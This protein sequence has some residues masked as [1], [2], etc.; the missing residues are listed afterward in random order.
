MP[1]VSVISNSFNS[2]IFGKRMYGR[3]DF[4]RYKNAAE[5]IENFLLAPQGGLRR[6]PGTA[7]VGEVRD[8]SKYVR[9]VDFEFSSVDSYVL[10]LNDGRIEFLRNNGFV[11][12]ATKNI[13]SATNDSPGVIEV[14]SHGFSNGDRVYFDGLGGMTEL[15]DNIY[16]IAGVTTHTFTLL[17]RAGSAVNTTGYG[18]YTTGGT[19]ARIYSIAHPYSDAELAQIKWAQDNDTIYV[20]CPTKMVR[21]IIRAG[22]TSWTLTEVEFTF[23]PF[24]KDNSVV[25]HTMSS[26]GTTG[27]VT[28]T[29]STAYFN[30]NHV[31][32]LLKMAG[33]T[34]TPARQGY[35]LITAYTSSTV[36]TGTVKHTLSSGSATDAWAI[37]S[38]SVDAGFPRAI[39]FHESRLYLGGTTK[40]PRN[41]WGSVVEDFENMEIDAEDDSALDLPILVVKGTPILWLASE[42]V[43]VA[44]SSDG[45]VKI[46]AGG[47]ST[48]TP[49]N[50]SAK[51]QTSVGVADVS[52]ANIGSFVYYIQRDK[53]TLREF[54]FVFESDRY[55]AHNM[56]VFADSIMS[57]GVV[58]MAFQQAP[59]GILYASLVD[60]KIITFTREREQEVMGYAEQTTDGLFKDVLVIS[61]ETFDEVWVIVSRTVDGTNRQY[62]EYFMPDEFSDQEDA[63]FVDSGLEYDASPADVFS[64]LEHLEGEIVSVLADGAVHPNCTVTDG[65]ITL[66]YDASRVIVGLPFESR[67]KTLKVDAGSA[68]GSAQN[69]TKRVNKIM[70]RVWDSLGM[71]VGSNSQ[72]DTVIFRTPSDLM[73]SPP[74]LFTGDK[75]VQA[76]HGYDRDGQIVI[77]QD[78]PLPLNISAV[79]IEMTEFDK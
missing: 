36:V 25:A 9:L 52:P 55:V 11:L 46:S 7:F 48:I 13:V 2:G 71:K 57:A 51:R 20:V 17:D 19:V 1:K 67:I 4:Q 53:K 70:V 5:E 14:A 60:G 47:D 26:S 68:I 12:E 75:E 78:Q 45:V 33:T 34:G 49:D 58:R 69:K 32:A 65:S 35:V 28:I 16:E 42:D 10:V 41:V 23:G 18:T 40:Q 79:V 29:S 39:S 6:R 43:L 50:L 44:G 30:T 63:F 15:N 37:G 24:Q 56:S 74:P 72:Q 64:G 76:P 38:F 66:D 54:K 31:G 22:H 61:K 8:S 59:D 27:S 77:L 62:I 21:K 73:G 3:T